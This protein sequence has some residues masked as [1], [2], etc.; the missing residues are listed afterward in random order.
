[1]KA[2]KLYV[3]FMIDCESTQSSINDPALGKRSS[4]GF[5]K[6]LEDRG[7]KGTF[8][9]ISTDAAASPALYREIHD[10]GHQVGLHIHPSEE[11]AFEEFLG[12]Y[13][14]DKQREILTIARDRFAQA[15]S[16]Q[17]KGICI[18]YVS[19]NDYTYGVM[20][21]MGF[22]HGVASLP[23]RVL[24]EC[25]SVHAGAPL[26]IHYAHPYNRLLSGNLD[27]VEIPLTVDIES[28]MWGGRH[29][30]DLRVELVDSK[31]HWYT[32]NKAIKRQIEDEVPI[33][34]LQVNTH[35][36]FAYDDPGD[37]R[38]ETLE[39]IIV[40]IRDIAE[41]NEL[42]VIASTNEET[43]E[44]YRRKVPLPESISRLELDR[45]GYLNGKASQD[46]L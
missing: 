8:Y 33:P 25:A 1:M 18:G 44:S 38:R 39:E 28:R 29:P 34:Y 36:T 20:S 42:D 16:F 9:L 41:Q 24:P 19:T 35:N 46:V 13:G 3:N 45:R 26:D 32:I 14:P 15:L 12:T 17:P 21:A 23:S 22:T 10:R 30:Q 7:L 31:N 40:H 11:G 43:A 6:V 37:F 5:M 27:F 4:R 2:D